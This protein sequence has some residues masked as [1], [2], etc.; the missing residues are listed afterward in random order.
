L[1]TPFPIEKILVNL[2]VTS[3]SIEISSNKLNLVGILFG[4]QNWKFTEFFKIIIRKTFFFFIVHWNELIVFFNTYHKWAVCRS[5]DL[6]MY[7][8]I[9]IYISY[10][11]YIPLLQQEMCAIFTPY[12]VGSIVIDRIAQSG[13]GFKSKLS[14]SKLIQGAPI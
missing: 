7:V 1:K 11:W 14:I 5:C 4:D 6:F 13:G 2:M 3:I 12:R 8:C 10:T 9:Y